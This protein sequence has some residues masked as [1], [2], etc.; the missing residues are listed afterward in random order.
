MPTHFYCFHTEM[1]ALLR[2]FVT[3]I[4]PPLLGH[5]GIFT[6]PA[7]MDLTS[8]WEVRG[9]FFPSAFRHLVDN[10]TISGTTQGKRTFPDR[11]QG[12]QMECCDNFF[13]LPK[14]LASI[15]DNAGISCSGKLALGGLICHQ[16]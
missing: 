12:L 8:R 1:C 4:D 7:V 10:V 16:F 5:L 14:R 9:C 6:V 13:M 3:W 2:D 11:M 15:R